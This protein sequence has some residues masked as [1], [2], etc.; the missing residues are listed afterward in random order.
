MVLQLIDFGEIDGVDFLLDLL[1]RLRALLDG[2]HDERVGELRASNR[3]EADDE[4]QEGV[5]GISIEQWWS[6]RGARVLRAEEQEQEHCWRAPVW[7]VQL[8]LRKDEGRT[9]ICG[10]KC[11]GSQ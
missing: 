1:L 11:C 10:S 3:G 7:R 6:G 2:G 8:S 4:R 5:C 9:L